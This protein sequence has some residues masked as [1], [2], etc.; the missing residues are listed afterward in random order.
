VSQTSEQTTTQQRP[1]R[2]SRVGRR[3]A[4]AVG[5]AAFGLATLASPPPFTAS[6]ALAAQPDGVGMCCYT[7]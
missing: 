3:V 1:G 5:A 6:V 2:R 7:S 4:L